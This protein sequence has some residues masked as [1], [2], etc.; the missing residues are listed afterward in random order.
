MNS[1]FGPK[2]QINAANYEQ[3]LKNA[4]AVDKNLLK[5]LGGVSE[6]MDPELAAIEKEMGNFGILHKYMISYPY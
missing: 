2:K 3:E 5:E 6:Q 1:A 4:M